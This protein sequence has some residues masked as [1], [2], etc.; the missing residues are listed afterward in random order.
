MKRVT[1]SIGKLSTVKIPAI[2]AVH[3]AVAAAA[4]AAGG[5]RYV[6]AS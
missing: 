2:Y 3:C 5:W 6:C 1:A 4:A